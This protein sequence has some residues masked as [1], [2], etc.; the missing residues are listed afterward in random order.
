MADIIVLGSNYSTTL[1]AVRAIGMAGYN[2]S[3]IST[4][5]ECASIVERSK[6]VDETC[7]CS[8]EYTD[9]F[10]SL[11]AMRGNKDKSLIFPTNDYG[12]SLLDLHMEELKEHYVFPNIEKSPEKMTAFMDKYK[13]KCLAAECGIAV[14]EGGIY[15]GSTD[16]IEKAKREV[17]YPCVVKAISS[18]GYLKSKTLLS[19]CNNKSELEKAMIA[20]IE[21]EWSHILVE[22]YLE[23]EKE[24]AVYGLALDG[25]VV[26]PSCLHTRRSGHGSHKGVTAEGV[27]LF[28]DFLGEDKNKLE[29]LVQRSGLNGLFCIDL[30]LSNNQIFFV[31]MNLRYGASG[32]AATM[33]GANLPGA[34]VDAML[35]N[36]E[37]DKN[38][39]M[40]YEPQFLNEKVELDDYRMGYIS[41]REYKAHQKNNMIRFIK[42]KDDPGPWKKFQSLERRK[43]MAAI[44]RGTKPRN[45]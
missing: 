26:L 20:A 39:R 6:Y 15:E 3:L 24:Y 7:T 41:W 31:E 42:S 36:K 28:P 1:G 27:M 32:F 33:A 17:Q 18:V 8:L 14:P 30:I 37:I 44:L 40:L 29:K 11:E 2:V 19:V 35:S 34:Y 23:I 13:Q 5:K 16:G 45:K 22:R 43:H 12:T 4:S 25:R 10:R 21:K 38:M 9:I